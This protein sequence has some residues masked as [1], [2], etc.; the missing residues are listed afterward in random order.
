MFLLRALGVQQVHIISIAMQTIRWKMPV[1]CFKMH[2]MYFGTVA[3]RNL[4]GN[5]E[6][7]LINAINVFYNVGS[8]TGSAREILLLLIYQ[9]SVKISQID[10]KI[11]YA[12]AGNI[13]R[14]CLRANCY[15]LF[16]EIN[17][18]VPCEIAEYST[19]REVTFL[20]EG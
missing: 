15:Y 16:K 12:C 6:H 18:Q 10:K 20:P 1:T 14:I 19:K 17:S 9:F 2:I 13:C 8:V 3:S 11:G 7:K 5:A 4:F